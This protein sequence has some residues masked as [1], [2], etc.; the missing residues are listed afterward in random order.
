M[1][2]TARELFYIV[3]FISAALGLLLIALLISYLKL[4]R[5]YAA[6]KDEEGNLKL[7]ISKQTS[8]K[9]NQTQEESKKI[10]EDAYKKAG[11]IVS[12]SEIFT[13]EEKQKFADLLTKV[14]NEEIQNYQA[15]LAETGK[16]SIK[17][18]QSISKDI[19]GQII[20][21]VEK[22]KDSIEN[23]I[24]KAGDDAKKMVGNTYATLSS[25]I[26][27]YKRTIFGEID[28]VFLN[29]IREMSIKV[30]GKVINKKEQEELVMKA[31]EEAKKQNIF[32]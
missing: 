29:V 23:E 5:K 19:E 22:I 2:T 9:M 15:V 3:A 18:I 10:L 14:A 21:E 26:E 30:L 12:A 32:S 1:D 4:V 25:E 24:Q 6:L 8:E 13:Q 31:L 27:N 11:E 17:T 20:P 16:V 7:D 28:E